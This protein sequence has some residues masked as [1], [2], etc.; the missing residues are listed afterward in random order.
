M[1]PLTT[2]FFT[3][4]QQQDHEDIEESSPIETSQPEYITSPRPSAGTTPSTT[5]APHGND[6]CPQDPTPF[7]DRRPAQVSVTVHRTAT[8][9]DPVEHSGVEGATGDDNRNSAPSAQRL[10]HR[11]SVHL[12][13][14][15]RHSS[16]N[17]TS[18]TPCPGTE[19]NITTS[20]PGRP[21]EDTPRPPPFTRPYISAR[22]QAREEPVE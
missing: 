9:T 4:Q 15:T 5:P 14:A 6:A 10:P 22:E 18:S 11:M 19:G 20:Y 12:S 8:A 16:E 1:E 13:A 3:P 2:Q 21:T 17:Q 7:P